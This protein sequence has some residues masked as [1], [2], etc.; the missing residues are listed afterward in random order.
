M[1]SFNRKYPGNLTSYSLLVFMLGAS[2]ISLPMMADQQSASVVHNDGYQQVIETW[3][4]KRHKSLTRPDGY[5][6]QV[7]LEWLKDGGEQDWQGRRQRYPIDWRASVLG[8]CVS[9]R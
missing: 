3:R 2:L 7:G 9:A 4:A 1:K 5:L 6:A 8:K